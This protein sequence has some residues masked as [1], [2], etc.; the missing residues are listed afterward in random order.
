MRRRF[1]RSEC[2]GRIE[3]ME[4]MKNEAICVSDDGAGCG[5]DCGRIDD[6][7]NEPVCGDV[8][9]GYGEVEI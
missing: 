7:T 4:E 6:G 8:E 3:T 1:G 2:G 9:A 5:G